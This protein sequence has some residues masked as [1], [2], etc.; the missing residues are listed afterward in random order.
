MAG[1]GHGELPQ[2]LGQGHVCN[3]LINPFQ[4]S[5]S[6][7]REGKPLPMIERQ[8]EIASES[9]AVRADQRVADPNVAP[10]LAEAEHSG[11]I[12]QLGMIVRALLASRAGK[13][14]V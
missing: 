1:G 12:S 8:E 13:S 7:S 4:A 6:V 9:G 3:E 14:I 11:L 10:E 5:R 2:L